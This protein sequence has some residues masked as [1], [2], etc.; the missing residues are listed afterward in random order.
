MTTV[1]KNNIID[2]IEKIERLNNAIDFHQTA[3][4]PNIL[5]IEQYQD[6]KDDLVIFLFSLLKSL[7]LNRPL[8]SYMMAQMA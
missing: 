1:D 3:E 7:K 4:Q 8:E 6:M 5:A 2:I